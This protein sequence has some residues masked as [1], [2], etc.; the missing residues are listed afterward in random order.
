MAG[1]SEND[2]PIKVVSA[3]ADTENNNNEMDKSYDDDLNTYF[4]SETLFDS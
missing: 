3:T 4:V 2:I 1:F